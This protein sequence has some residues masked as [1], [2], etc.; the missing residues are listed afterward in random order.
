MIPE[1]VADGSN[2]IGLIIV[3]GF[4]SAFFLTSIN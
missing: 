2:L 3:L 4:A 1:A